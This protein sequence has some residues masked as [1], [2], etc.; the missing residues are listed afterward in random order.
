LFSN[1]HLSVIKGY[2]PWVWPPFTWTCLL[3]GHQK[4]HLIWVDSSLMVPS[5]RLLVSHNQDHPPLPDHL[6]NLL[7]WVDSIKVIPLGY[8]QYAP[9]VL[10]RIS[11]LILAT[12]TFIFD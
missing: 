2:S 7:I 8:A 11:L 9:W 12:L 4:N 6:E 10:S 5:L 3:L 1:S